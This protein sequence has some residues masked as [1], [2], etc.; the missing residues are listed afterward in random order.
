MK[1]LE[2]LY[3][4]LKSYSVTFLSG[5][6]AMEKKLGKMQRAFLVIAFLLGNSQKLFK[7]PVLRFWNL[8]TPFR[9]YPEGIR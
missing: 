4:G 2:M 7:P 1:V 9:T 5:L 8:Y 3:D 6:R